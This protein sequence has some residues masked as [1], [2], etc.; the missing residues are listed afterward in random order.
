MRA[1]NLLLGT[2]KECSDTARI[3]LL[4]ENEDSDDSYDS[5]D[6]EE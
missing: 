6:E 3:L 1:T 4:D 2:A 5:D